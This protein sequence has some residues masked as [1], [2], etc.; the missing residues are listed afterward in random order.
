MSRMSNNKAKELENE[1]ENWI[2]AHFDPMAGFYTFSPCL[3]LTDLNGDGDYKLLLASLGSGVYNMKLKVFKGTTLVQETSL[4]DLPVGICTFYMDLHEPRIPGIAVASGPFLYV[5]KNMRPYYKFTLPLLPINPIESDIWSQVSEDKIDIKSLWTTLS[6][7]KGHLGDISLTPRSLQFL[8]LETLDEQM[9]FVAHH[10]STPLKRQTV[11]TCLSTM[12]KSVPED[13]AISCVVVATESKEIYILDSE[14]FSIL[15]KN[16]LPDTPAFINTSGLYDVDFRI[17]VA[18]RSGK[19]YIVKKDQETVYLCLE[20]QSQIVGMERVHKHLIIV[21]MDNTLSCYTGK[22]KRLWRKYLTT[23][24]VCTCLMDHNSKGFKAVLVAL[25]NGEVQVYRDKYLVDSI[26]LREPAQALFFGKYGREDSTLIVILRS[27]AMNLLIM[28]RTAVYNDKDTHKGPPAAQ[29]IKLNISKKTQI[30]VDQTVRERENGIEMFQSCQN[31]VK[32][33][34]LNTA[35]TYLKALD[36]ST[37][38]LST[39]PDVPLKISATVQGLG[40]V[41]K[42]LITL[43]NSNANY[44]VSDPKLATDLKLCFKYSDLTYKI[45]PQLLQVPALVPGVSYRLEARVE[46]I[47]SNRPAKDEI[48]ALILK[49]GM[50]RPIVTANIFMPASEATVVV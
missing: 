42:L 39:D 15:Q 6:S 22:G 46:C 5:Y 35:A 8:L 37:T 40:P 20:L 2:E 44:S 30:F 32:R 27:G 47:I 7:I 31:D 11:I 41:F 26:K 43:Q 3:S 36:S 9:E 21:C 28:K 10:K 50:T 17:F 12:K 29:S 16:H 14:A 13:D 1:H 18:C 19:V 49:N 48:R 24:A 34:K 4:L 23:N 25:E 38:P 45:S 33:F